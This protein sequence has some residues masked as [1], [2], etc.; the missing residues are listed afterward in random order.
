[1]ITGIEEENQDIVPYPR[2]HMQQR[3]GLGLKRRTQDDLRPECIHSP[4]NDFLG[5]FRLELIRELLDLE[6]RKHREIIPVIILAW[7]QTLRRA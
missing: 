7:I 3:H 5:S 4:F 2:G 6:R 1:M